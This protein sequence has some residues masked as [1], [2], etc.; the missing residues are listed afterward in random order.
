MKLINMTI[1]QLLQHYRNK[2]FTPRELVENL[3][4]RAQAATDTHA[5][6]HLMS[7]AEIQPYLD[8]LAN[9]SPEDLPLYGIPFAIKDNIDLAGIPTTAACPAFSYLPEQSAFVVKRLLEAGAIPLGKTNLDQFATGL[10]GTR[11]PYGATTNP[12]NPA[13]IAGGSSS[14]SAVAVARGLVSFALGTDTAGS[15]RVPAAFNNILGLK[16]SRGLLSNQGVVPACKSLDCV[17]LFATTAEDLQTLFDYLAVYDPADAYARRNPLRNTVRTATPERFSFAVPQDTQLAFFGDTE[18]QRLFAQTVQQLEQVGGEKHTIDFAPFL[19]AARLL[20]EGPWVTERYLACQPLIDEQ[21]EAMLEVTRNIIAPGKA[22]TASD[23]FTALYKLQA[24]K[25]QTDAL[26]A[27]YDYLLTPTAGTIYTIDEI[28]NDPIRLNANLGYY[29]NYMN[30]L[31]YSAVAVPAGMTQDGL[32]FGV[33]LVA[34][35]F[36]DQKLIAYAQHLQQA[37]GLPLGATAWALPAPAD[38]ELTESD[39]LDLVVCGAHLSGLPLN[40]QLLSRGATLLR[41]CKSAPNYKLYALPGGP[42]SRPG[43]IRVEQGGSAIEVEVW[44]VPR[45]HV[46]SFLD[47]IPHPLGLGKVELEDGSWASGFI[48]EAYVSDAATDIS[49]LGGWRAYLVTLQ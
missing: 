35:A 19:N 31:D 29:T 26:L 16:P 23:T 47:G 1:P 33:T 38:V 11:S 34:Q 25:Q 6:I 14:G 3:L 43:M 48:C 49:A 7:S 2:D 45:E 20:Y 22:S 18:Y 41:Q 42:P 39:T 10:V 36:H 15:G 9:H 37:L 4:E 13:Y 12:F 17:A 8:R 28:N 21:P 32:P 44:R 27:P 5:W 24:Y 30:L 40:H 46:G